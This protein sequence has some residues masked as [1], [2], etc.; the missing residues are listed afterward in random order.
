[1]LA[2]WSQ[3]PLIIF[4][5][6]TQQRRHQLVLLYSKGWDRTFALLT[7]FSLLVLCHFFLFSTKSLSE[8][9][10]VL[11]LVFV[12]FFYI[13]SWVSVVAKIFSTKQW[14]LF[15]SY[16]FFFY[17]YGFDILHYVALN[18]YDKI[19]EVILVQIFWII[20]IQS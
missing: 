5:L 9:N 3:P 13:F 12:W 19:R 2:L 16:R 6:H 4:G 1:M 14:R 18:L 10:C 7:I 8:S 17:S 15:F 11:C 20:K